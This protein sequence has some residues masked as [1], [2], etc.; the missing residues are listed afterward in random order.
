MDCRMKQKKS[1]EEKLDESRRYWS[2]ELA[3]VDGRD[4]LR[5]QWNKTYLLQ[6]TGKENPLIEKEKK[7]KKI[8][9]GS[10]GRSYYSQG[11]LF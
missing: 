7:K 2:L 9:V 4:W 5:K 10:I 11:L 1:D 6:S 3:N 8:D